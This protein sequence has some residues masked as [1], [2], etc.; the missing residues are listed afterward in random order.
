MQP[1]RRRPSHRIIAS[2]SLAVAL[3]S[4]LFLLQ[5]APHAHAAGQDD[6]AC[7]LCQVAHIG[8]APAIAAVLLGLTLL[9][10]GEAPALVSVHFS[11]PFFAYSRPRAP[12][13]LFA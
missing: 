4:L 11:E 5:V 1:G 10:F 7:R 12:P 6:P 3:V 2:V 9:Y 8:I 13:V